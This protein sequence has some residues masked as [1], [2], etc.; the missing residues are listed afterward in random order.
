MTIN[1]LVIDDEADIRDLI[2]DIL[3]DQ[4]FAVRAAADSVKTFSLLNE[5][6]PHI[7]IL[8]IWLQGSEIDGLG[9][10]EIIKKHYSLLPVIVI[11][12]HGT[13]EIAV[14]SIKI[15][16]FDYIE[17]PF[18]QE[19]LLISLKRA[20]EASKLKKENIDLRKMLGTTLELIGESQGVIK[21]KNDITKAAAS[22]G[23]II[24]SG[25]SGSGKELVAK[26]IHKNSF[27]NNAPFII[28]SPSGLA[29]NQVRDELFGICTFDNNET[30]V[31]RRTGLLEL[32]NGGTLFIDEISDLS[33]N[34]QSKLI[35]FLQH[36]SIERH[37]NK[38]IKVNVRLISATC[39]DL[40]KK[41]EEKNFREDLYH[42]L[43]NIVIKVPTLK[44]RK[45]DIPL[46]IEYFTK[47]ILKSF[48]IRREYKF[49]EETIA[50]L[51]SYNWPGNI[52]QMKNILEWAIIMTIAN[53]DQ[54]AIIHPSILPQEILKNYSFTTIDTNLNVVSMPLRE[55]RELFE[56]EYLVSQLNRFN[57]NISKTADFIG[58]ER[59]ALHRKLKILN[60]NLDS[61]D[62]FHFS[63]EE[64]IS[65][66]I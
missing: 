31:L 49:S 5:K 10:L 60:I 26:L 42:K 12:G 63:E 56:K 57:N 18:T 20:L 13:I 6:L 43:N 55:A 17:K 4:G 24:I 39:F 27:K 11:S 64:K 65:K 66:L 32:A 8:D 62:K 25:P 52:R 14:K 41:I 40:Q 45:E 59:S 15:G 38:F 16:A 1:V 2:T 33:L 7:I 28:F 58:M 50:Y 34:I 47:Q 3:Q 37:K 61:F 53:N 44:H 22:T 54:N 21:L 9:I 23:R 30:I 48:N 29:D 35:N 19:K 51:Q 46:L 36:Q